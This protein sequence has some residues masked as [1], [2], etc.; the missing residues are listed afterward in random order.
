MKKLHLTIFVLMFPVLLFAQIDTTET[1]EDIETLLEDNTQDQEDSQVY[2][3]FEYLMSNP[4]QLNSASIK[5]LLQIPFLNISTASAI[6]RHR[7]KLGGIY[8]EDQLKNIDGVD[9]NLLDRIKP[10]L[11]LGDNEQTSAFYSI[12]QLFDDTKISFR[13]RTIYDLQPRRGF[14]ESIFLGSRQKN[15]NR[16][17]VNSSDRIKAG[18][19][20]EKDAGEK[21]LTD[22]TSFNISITDLPVAQS[23]VLGNY[24]FEFGQGLAVWSPYGFSKGSNTVASATRNSR[25]PVPFISSDENQFMQG[26][27]AKIKLGDFSFSPFYSSHRIDSSIDSVTNSVTSIV[28]DGYHRTD[29]EIKKENSLRETMFG[30]GTEY[31]FDETTRFGFLYY[32]SKYDHNLVESN[33]LKSKFE[34]ISASYSTLI[35]KLLL[36][37]EFAS[38]KTSVSSIN[39]AELL[40]DKNF[41]LVF[42]YRNFAANYSVIHGNSFGE[43]GSAKN[44]SGFYTGIYWRTQFGIFNIYY[45]Q[46]KFPTASNSYSFPSNGNDFLIN[47]SYKPFVNTEIRIRY[48]TENKDAVIKLQNEIGLIKQKTEKL[49]GEILYKVSKNVRLR[50]R[51]ET[52]NLSAIPNSPKEN[53]YLLFQDVNFVLLKDLTIYGRIIFF[54]T[55]SYNS[56]VYEFE[57]DLTGIMTNPALFGEGTR[58]YFIA[59]YKTSLGLNISLKYSELYKPYEKS[60]GSGYSEI[61]GNIDNRISFQLDFKL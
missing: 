24:I 60:L 9:N 8:S 51:F 6:I 36:A 59:R 13:S 30:L 39:T 5:E 61:T 47:Y 11:K 37:G 41:S 35:N 20:I 42:S 23:L 54:H 25:G 52:V 50:T 40:I 33:N 21:S 19:L 16:L 27:A 58:W 49:R 1:N 45:D 43:R 53:G 38:D 46:F 2:D 15:Y 10:F 55:D 34:Y 31:S 56:R 14:N 48:K 12:S 17:I 29:N 7:N 28:I 18:V 4:I 32:Q 44:E 22:F 26:A 3:L 57:N